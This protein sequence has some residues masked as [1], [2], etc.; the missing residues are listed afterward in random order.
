MKPKVNTTHAEAVTVILRN[1]N[2]SDTKLLPLSAKSIAAKILEKQMKKGLS[3]GMNDCR[4]M[5]LFFAVL[6]AFFIFHL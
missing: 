3:A 4:R 1:R 2:G 5:V 6:I